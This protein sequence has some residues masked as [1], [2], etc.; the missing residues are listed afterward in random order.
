M[1]TAPVTAP[2]RAAAAVPAPAPT[3][4][5]APA[6]TAPVVAPVARPPARQ[7]AAIPAAADP[8][9]GGSVSDAADA[10]SDVLARESGEPEAPAKPR[11]STPAPAAEAEPEAESKPED[12]TP[13]A[14]D[15]AD[16]AEDDEDE[17]EGEDT[18]EDEEDPE[19]EEPEDTVKVT[20]QVDGKTEKVSLADLKNGFL[21]QSDYTRKTQALA[22]ERNAFQGQRQ[23]ID[24]ERR[25]YAQLLPALAK[26][27]MGEQPDPSTL[28]R[29][30][31]E[32]PVQYM[33]EREAM[34]D[35]Q[36]RIEAARQEY[37]R[38]RQEQAQEVEAET[39]ARLNR[40]REALLQA[41]PAWKDA[42]RRAKDR[43]AIRQYGKK[44]GWSDEEL[45]AVT[46][47]RAV[48]VLLKAMR[49]DTAASK[50][51]PRPL[52]PSP[53]AP[54]LPPQAARTVPPR[55]VTELTRAKQ[56]LAKT[57]A[58]RDAAAVIERLL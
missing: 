23:A 8:L 53:R 47:H 17:A 20:V 16:E 25:Q 50:P 26:Q 48:L 24:Q 9:K 37:E 7:V 27:V 28:E 34:R 57:G 41:I 6:P 1:A 38:I 58:A 12:E 14:E 56:R 13:P 30:R 54:S 18:D 43:E 3:P 31:V 35:R 2:A 10:L 55:Q 11:R 22:E 49:Y 4:A 21:R 45:S 46:D 36:E 29:L 42:D 52:P 33:L 32:D 5:P 40:E 39:I 51:A 15:E 19:G 44:L